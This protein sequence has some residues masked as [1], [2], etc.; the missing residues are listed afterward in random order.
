MN[1]RAV[2]WFAAVNVAGIIAAQ[3]IDLRQR[4]ESRSKQFVVYSE[5]VRLRQRVASFAEEM[6]GLVL[7]LLHEGDRWRAPVVITLERAKTGEPP[8]PARLRFAETEPGFKIEM[9]IK[10]G[11][12]PQAVNL[13]KM[14]L[15]ASLIEY[16]YREKGITA[17]ETVIE[18]P[19]WVVEGLIEMSGRRGETPDGGLFRRLIDTNR[20]PPLEN[21]LGE[22]PD[23]LGPTAL[24][25]DRALAMSLLQLLVEQPDGRTALARLVRDWPQSNGDPVALLTRNFPGLGKGPTLQKWWTLS[26]AR[27]AA[28]DRYQGLTTEESEATLAPLLE[29]ELV[30][31]KAGEKK[32]FAVGEFAQ[33]LKFPASRAVLEARHA[34]IV[35]LSTRASALYRPVVADYEGIFALLG[36]RK[37][38]GLRTR[39]EQVEEGRRFV[40]RRTTEIADYLNWF[41]ATQMQTRSSAFD[42]YLKTARELSEQDQKNKGPV[43][44]Y[45]DELEKEL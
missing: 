41:E 14:L 34:E 31:N 25:V 13:Q 32:K 20:L 40:L 43:G 8:L 21:F 1:R 42:D 12:D 26:L 15:R 18:P 17:G 24:A 23:E 38:R 19:W 37:T 3:A 30:I 33:Y 6:K 39:L 36:Q 35:A 45:L 11:D 29:F 22:K 28:V 16:A 4:S 44:R 5:D 2:L 27:F 7:E 10:I 9:Q